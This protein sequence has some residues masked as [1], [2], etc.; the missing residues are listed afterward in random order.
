[1]LLFVREVAVRNERARDD[2]SAGD[3]GYVDGNEVAQN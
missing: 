2:D 3:G 1:M